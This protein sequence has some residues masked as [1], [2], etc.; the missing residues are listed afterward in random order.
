LGQSSLWL[1]FGLGTA[2]RI[3]R[4]VVHWPGGVS[5]QWSD[6]PIDQ[7]Y[8]IVQGE[9]PLRP[10]PARSGLAK[11]PPAELQ[12]VAASD[13]TQN[14][15]SSSLPLPPLTY[16]DW[17][18]RDWPLANATQTRLVVLWASW[19][20]PCLA[21]LQ[22]LGQSAEAQRLRQAGVELLALSVDRVAADAP[23]QD[24]SRDPRQLLAE[25]GYT[26]SAGWATADL[27]DKLQL[28]HNLLLDRHRPL[29]VPCSL[30]LEPSG[31]LAAIY[32]GPVATE[33]VLADV[34]WL[35]RDAGARRQR[36]VPLAGRWF[37]PVAQPR[38][39]AVA[40]GLVDQGDL[41][42]AV[43]Y[44]RDHRQ[45]LLED[46][47]FSKLLVHLGNQLFVADQ[48]EPAVEQYQAALQADPQLATAHL[49]LAVARIKQRRLGEA[50][51]SLR[52]AIR[53]WPDYG[54]AHYQLGVL[55]LQTRRVQQALAPL[56]RAV[57]LRPN[58]RDY[59]LALAT[60]AATMGDLSRAAEQLEVAITADDRDASAW[61]QLGSVRM[62]QGREADAIDSLQQALAHR[63]DWPLVLD[64]L[65]WLLATT[66]DPARRDAAR[67]VQLAE[68]ACRAETVP[69]PKRLDTLA[70]AYAAAGRFDDAV[71]TAEQALQLAR[72]QQQTRLAEGIAQRLESY[73]AGRPL[74]L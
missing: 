30:L 27:L 68:Q 69:H 35:S 47:Q 9:T 1:T 66:R 31:K 15:L 12:P 41:A 50:E 8:E 67:A 45:A 62:R 73:R 58:Q 49:N 57:E 38:P 60:A 7:A 65:A 17:E 64:D 53:C 36:S 52:E 3:E 5:Q 63:P 16:Q 11:L 29:P 33:R 6:V 24:G 42:D 43:Q 2:E 44:A 34:Q 74:V 25:L 23:R 14:L 21:E 37:G 51:A 32:K 18:G 19:C 54:Q 20:Q 26:Q 61:A 22:Q 56:A 40:W 71:R 59:R 4:V 39:S 72:R 70:A 55:L 48:V 46:D 10:R 28:V 13:V